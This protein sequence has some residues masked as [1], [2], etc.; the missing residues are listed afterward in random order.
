MLINGAKGHVGH[1]D[2]V[3]G[4]MPSPQWVPYPYYG[5]WRWSFFAKNLHVGRE[6]QW[7]IMAYIATRVTVSSGCSSLSGSMGPRAHTKYLSQA[8]RGIVHARWVRNGLC[9]GSF[10]DSKSPCLKGGSVADCLRLMSPKWL[11]FLIG[12]VHMDP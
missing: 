8:L 10:L 5:G 3:M 7:P 9:T 1:L 11:S 4:A 12:M 6:I 2:L